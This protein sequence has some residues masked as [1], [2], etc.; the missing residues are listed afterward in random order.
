MW[1][2]YIGMGVPQTYFIDAE[3]IVRAFSL[4][5]FSDAGPGGDGLAAILPAHAAVSPTQG[6]L[7]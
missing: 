7:R 2:D 1:R 6:V 5:P 4:G 3:G